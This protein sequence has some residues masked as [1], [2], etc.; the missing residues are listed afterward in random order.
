MQAHDVLNLPREGYTVEQLKYNYKALAR[1]LHPDKRRGRMTAEQA[2][3]MFQVLTAAYR[4]LLARFEEAG[5]GRDGRERTHRELRDEARRHFDSAG[6]APPP[7][8]RMAAA[9]A[10]HQQGGFNVARFNDVFEGNR[11]PDPVVDGG[12]GRWMSDTDPDDAARR[13]KDER[14]LQLAR[15]VEPTPV[16]VS[17][18]GCVAYSELGASGVEDYSRADAAGQAIQF[19]DYRLAHTTSRLADERDFEAVARRIDRELRSVE[20]LKKHRASDA[21]LRMSASEASRLEAK[22]RERVEAE[23][24]RVEALD[25]YDRMIDRVH[26]RT[27]MLLENLR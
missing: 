13:R 9:A 25:A 16:A 23:R 19:T 1:Q 6:G 10:D 2:T 22:A 12:Y 18:R 8:T 27:S 26:G 20:T 5:G 7:P 15:V 11:L 24:R 17:R 3:E 21:S 4:A 14:R